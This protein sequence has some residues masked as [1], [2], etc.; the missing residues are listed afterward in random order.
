VEVAHQ[1]GIIHRD[2]KPEN[3]MLK[4]STDGTLTVKVVDFGLAKLVTGDGT[5][6]GGSNLTQT[7]EVLGTPHYMAPE[8][9]EGESVDNRADIYAIG[10]ILY[11][12]ISG[13]APFVGTVQSIIGGHLFKDPQPLFN[14]NPSVN[15]KLN[16]VVMRAL[17][18]R[19]DERV[20]S[21]AEFAKLLKEIIPTLG[22]PGSK[23]E[24][25]PA[26]ALAAQQNVV[27]EAQVSANLAAP[28]KQK[29]ATG[30]IHSGSSTDH[31]SGSMN[32]NE[33]RRDTTEVN[34]S[35]LTMPED[36]HRDE[37]RNSE[38]LG[39]SGP[40]ISPKPR[41]QTQAIVDNELPGESE[42]LMEMIVAMKRELIVGSV[43]VTV[44]ALALVAFIIQRTEAANANI[45]VQPL[46]DT[47]TATQ[48]Q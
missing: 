6:E 18:K 39:S 8:Y 25:V 7:G 9:Y 13:D 34:Y 31:L 36:M 33:G 47:P 46:T 23:A 45:K 2:L 3:V 48:S 5:K 29:A 1:Q 40:L 37:L 15:E 30:L 41:A 38:P 44:M 19:R 21:A 28:E 12:M 16:D 24:A 26:A 17:K 11:E 42:T 35:T 32:V 20:G 14:M 27:N 43:I 22:A 10:V 4:E